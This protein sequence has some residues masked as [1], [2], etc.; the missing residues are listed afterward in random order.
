MHHYAPPI[1]NDG[2]WSACTDEEL[3]D[4]A[5]TDQGAFAALYQ[6]YQPRVFAYLLTYCPSADEA[7]D[8][9]QHVFLRVLE[10]LPSYRHR[11]APFSAW[12]FRIARNAAVDLHRRRQRLLPWE[13]LPAAHLAT[14]DGEPEALSV[15][16]DDLRRVRDLVAQLS[17]DQQELLALRFAAGLTTAEIASQTSKSEAATRKQ[18]WRIIQR[19]QERFDGSEI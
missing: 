13:H 16:T 3:I 1:E 7:T 5:C 2:S 4:V 19:L 14:S 18:L 12:L 15:Q 17:A 6:R 11:G 8:L 10:A 9:T